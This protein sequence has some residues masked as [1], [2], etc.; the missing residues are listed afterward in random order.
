MYHQ[1]NLNMKKISNIYLID[2][3][4]SDCEYISTLL[5]G[6]GYQVYEFESS[7]TFLR[8]ATIIPPAIILI[9]IDLPDMTGL[10]LQKKLNGFG[11]TT[12]I[13]FLCHQ[14]NSFHIVDGF[15]NGANDFIF[16]PIKKQELIKIVKNAFISQTIIG[17]NENTTQKYQLLLKALTPRE[18]EIHTYLVKG[19]MSKDIADLLNISTS[20]V[21]L[22]KSKVM[23]KMNV[24]SLQALTSQY[25]LHRMGK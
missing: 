2:D 8:G 10:E 14:N 6:E 18:K 16:K 17:H 3:D 7:K 5:R 25:L 13:I 21:K 11:E 9:D 15:R 23:S 20:T 1:K 12:P 4:D 22:H 19:Y 24:Y